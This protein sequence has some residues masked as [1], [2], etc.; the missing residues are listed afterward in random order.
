MHA[1]S[2]SRFAIALLAS[3]WTAGTLAAEMDLA[4]RWYDKSGKLEIEVSHF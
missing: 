3:L 4:D 1:T 2:P